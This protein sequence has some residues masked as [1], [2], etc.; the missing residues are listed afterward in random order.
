MSNERGSFD[1]IG[2]VAILELFRT[3]SDLHPVVEQGGIAFDC[4]ED[5]SH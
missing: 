1:E 5:F 2:S 3:F 4:K